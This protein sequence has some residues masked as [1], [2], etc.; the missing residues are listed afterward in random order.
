MFIIVLRK[1]DKL[2]E[3]VTYQ[4]VFPSRLL[5]QKGALKEMMDFDEAKKCAETFKERAKHENPRFVFEFC[6]ARME[7]VA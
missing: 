7:I 2:S 5:R 6:V 3:I 4:Q 1:T